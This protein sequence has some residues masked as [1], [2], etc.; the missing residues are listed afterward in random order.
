MLLMNTLQFP[1]TGW[2]SGVTTTT[3]ILIKPV[4]TKYSTSKNSTVGSHSL[5]M[6]I[7]EER[8]PYSPKEDF[9]EE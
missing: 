3:D 5:G 2:A 6:D 7:E 4:K 1:V 8:R 9:V